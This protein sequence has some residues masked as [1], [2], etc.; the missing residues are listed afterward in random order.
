MMTNLSRFRRVVRKVFRNLGFQRRIAPHF[1]DVMHA[2]DIDVVFDVGANDGD[3]GREI[4][5]LGY[6]GL[7]VSFEPN[8]EAYDRLQAA[9]APVSLPNSVSPLIELMASFSATDN[10]ASPSSSPKANE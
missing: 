5:D 8:P 3:Y 9:I 7:I 6:E 2:H 10:S 1:V 4:R